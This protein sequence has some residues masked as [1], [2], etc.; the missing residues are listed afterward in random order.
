MLLRPAKI[1][2]TPVSAQVGLLSSFLS[3]GKRKLVDYILLKDPKVVSLE[4]ASI[5]QKT[6]FYMHTPTG[7]SGYFTSQVLSQYPKTLITEE[8]TDPLLSVVKGNVIAVGVLNLSYTHE[9][10]IKTYTQFQSISPL[11]SILAFFS[12]LGPTEQAF[13]QIV[14]KTPRN[15]SGKQRKIRSRMKVVDTEG[16]EESNPYNT[17]IT[18]KLSTPLL[19][20]QIRIIVAGKNRNVAVSKLA[21]FAGIFG[22]YTLSEGNSFVYKQ[23]KGLMKKPLFQK[24]ARREFFLFQKTLLLNLEELSSLWH[25]PDKSL[26]K[27]KSIHWGKTYISEAPDNLPVATDEGNK[28]QQSDTLTDNEDASEKEQSRSDINFFARTEWRNREEIFGIAHEDRRKHMYVIG[29]TGAGKSTLIANMAINDIRNGH[30]VAVVD[31][32]GDLS[33]MI[34]NFIPKRRINDVIYLDPTLAADRSFSLNLF[35][36]EGM[37]HT[38]VV[39]SGIVSVFY[40]LYQNSWG[41]RLEYMLRNT[42]LSLLLYEDATF[43]DIPRMLT[44]KQYRSKVVADLAKKDTILSQFWIDEFEKMSDRLRTEAISPILN[45]VGQF[46]SSQRIRSI[47][48]SKRSTFSLDEVMNKG[49]ILILNL[50]QGKL[51]EDTTA[52][53]GAMFITKIQLTA[54]RRVFMPEEER[55]DFY[56]YVDEF[57]NFATNSFIKI[58]SEARK[59]KLN[60]TLANQYVG[61]VDEDIQKAIFGNVGTLVTFV[62]GARDAGLFEKEFGGKFTADDLV[63]LGKFQTLMKMSIGGL[64]SDPFLATTLGLPSVVNNNKEKIIRR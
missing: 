53:L 56:L 2:E 33:E 59:Y 5:A 1:E 12:K 45:K 9:Y 46:L 25:L 54:M 55:R 17:L 61:Q 51:G 20:A 18:Q 52:L 11:S 4:I 42:I 44:N 6:R 22:I 35:D 40:K 30:G 36:Q 64:T 38:D 10:P 34:L 60:L 27:I 50:S 14:I 7:L 3:I 16:K 13:F 29:K 19:E 58:L 21:E 15:Q 31:P 41:P 49:K 8:Q 23:V 24:I 28:L 63:A 47:V 39:A 57:Q 43:A 32:H 26:E 48:D 37:Q 62:V